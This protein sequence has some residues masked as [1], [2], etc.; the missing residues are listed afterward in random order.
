MTIASMS[1]TSRARPAAPRA[2]CRQIEMKTMLSM[3][4]TISSTVSV[5]GRSS[6]RDLPEVPSAPLYAVSTTIA[7]RAATISPIVTDLAHTSRRA[8]PVLDLHAPTGD[9]RAASPQP[10]D[11]RLAEYRPEA[12]ALPSFFSGRSAAR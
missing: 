9:G 7:C 3:P 4:R 5:T 6:L 8:L 10:D 11:G 2:A 12:Q 1:P